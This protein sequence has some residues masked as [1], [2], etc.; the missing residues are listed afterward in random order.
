MVMLN[1]LISKLMLWLLFSCE[2]VLLGGGGA[3]GEASAGPWLGRS[4][5]E[6]RSAGAEW[7]G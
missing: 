1:G 6:Q 5:K 3:E 7:S 2:R 4:W